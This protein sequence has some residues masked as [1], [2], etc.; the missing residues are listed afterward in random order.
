MKALQ[1]P[2]ITQLENLE[3]GVRLEYHVG[4]LAYDRQ[5]MDPAGIRL[6]KVATAAYALAKKNRLHLVAKKV[7]VDPRKRGDDRYEYRAIGRQ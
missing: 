1:D 5:R 4:Q 6:H 2:M 7:Y 3:R